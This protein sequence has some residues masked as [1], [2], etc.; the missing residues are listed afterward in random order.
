M[1]KARKTKE[2]DSALHRVALIEQRFK[3]IEAEEAELLAAH[4]HGTQSNT[5]S[6]SPAQN[7]PGEIGD[8]A[9]VFKVRY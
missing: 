4:G 2:R 8:K 1:E 3:E 5:T 7:S 6:H 9:P